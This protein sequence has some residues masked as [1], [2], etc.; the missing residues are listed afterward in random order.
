[1]SA[2]QPLNMVPLIFVFI[3]ISL[4][5]NSEINDNVTSSITHNLTIIRINSTPTGAEVWLDDHYSGQ[6]TPSIFTFKNPQ[7]HSFELRLYGY[8]WQM[9]NLNT[10]NSVDVN[11]NFSTGLDFG[12]GPVFPH[13]DVRIDSNPQGAEIYKDG[14][15]TGKTTP[16]YEPV[17][18][19]EAHDYYICKEGYEDYKIQIITDG[20]KNYEVSLN[21]TI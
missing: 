7:I 12:R 6:H 9:I 2:K 18:V 13:V 11:A 15:N 17:G 10:S 4:A 21:E 5:L 19:Y 3:S 1:M 16:Y 8:D 20:D 14:K